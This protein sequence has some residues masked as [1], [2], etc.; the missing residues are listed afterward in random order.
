MACITVSVESVFLLPTGVILEPHS[1]VKTPMVRKPMH[2]LKS[3][4]AS[5]KKS[6]SNSLE[7]RQGL[8]ETNSYATLAKGKSG[9]VSAVNQYENSGES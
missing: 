5:F 8:K 2:M 4:G 3:S 6:L 1:N 9:F 7:R